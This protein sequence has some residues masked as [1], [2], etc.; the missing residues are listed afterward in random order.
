MSDMDLDNHFRDLFENTS[1]LIYF[2]NI[3]GTIKLV[4]PAWLTTLGYEL[5]EVTGRSIFDF[6]HQDYID[7]YKAIR[8]DVIA[9]NEI[10]DFE[11]AF[12]TRQN[13]TVVGEGQVRCSYRNAELVYTRCVFKNIT[14]RRLAEKKVKESEKRL[15]AF[16]NSGPDAV[17]IINEYQEI[18]EWN[19]KAEAIFG[20]T[21]EEISGKTLA[22]TIIP[23]QYREAHI[24]GMQHFLTTGEGAVLNK[25]I[26]ITALHKSG[27]EFFIS[28]SISNV[29]LDD[30]WLFIAF[31]S[32]ISERKKTEEAL[33]RREAE[34][35][36]AKL[37]EQKKD[38]FISIASHEFK[39]PITTIKA[40]T[41]IAL[42][43]CKDCPEDVL[44]YLS[45][46]NQTVNKLTFLLNELLDVSKL[47]LGKLALFRTE[48]NMHEF[49][50][51]VLNSVQHISITHKIVLEQNAVSKTTIDVI[52]LEQVITNLVSNAAK[53]SPGRDKIIVKSTV[54]GDEIIISFT[55]YGI[56]IPAE[57][58]DKVFDRFYRADE[59]EQFSGFGIG[60]FVSSEIIKQ[61][62]GKIWA[63]ST[64]EKGST[65]Y[66]SLPLMQQLV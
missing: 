10:K 30:R 51:E 50:P 42:A 7:S 65:F 12:L 36:Q 62:G 9:N 31:L 16:F 60:L 46:M 21:K 26:E 55:D 18:V 52:R 24:K 19:P 43:A 64:E 27:K 28:L 53:Y 3:D 39:T 45:K 23:H 22:E 54:V 1:D 33:V 13:K 2:L 61:H 25:T 40:Y 58:V 44:M 15:K 49:L 34:L 6:V 41:Q 8:R 37:L 66:F 57:K 5:G 47:H 4:N 48:T 63:E 59:S 29:M 14:N 32:D 56:G 38:E 35:M 17:I 11:L 20:F